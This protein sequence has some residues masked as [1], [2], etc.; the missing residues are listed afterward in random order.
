MIRLYYARPRPAIPGRAVFFRETA[1]ILTDM[2]RKVSV[3]KLPLRRLLWLLLPI[4]LA[5][6]MC[7]GG[8][9]AAGHGDAPDIY[10]LLLRSAGLPA[11]DPEPVAEEEPEPPEEALLVVAKAKPQERIRAVV[12][13]THTSE[14]YKGQS[15]QKGVPGGVLEA[16][17]ELARALTEQGLEV[18]FDETVHDYDYDAAYSHS[19][20][21][22]EEIVAAYPDTRLFIDVHRDSAIAGIS[23]TLQA[24]GQDYAKMLLI[25]GS[26]EN[27]PHENWQA[28]YAF[29]KKVAA[30]TERLLPGVMREPRVYS[31]RYNQH[32]GDRALLVE[33]GSTDNSVEEARRSAAVL[34]RA[35]AAS[36]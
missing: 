1:H 21:A 4:L 6:L 23:T 29:A 16:A 2:K 35:I 28:N 20:A 10:E 8:P 11:L 33:I 25:V 17:R 22:L 18:I 3:I 7:R 30:E 24:E 32:I 13:C 26:D 15:R 14:E 5:A 19:L 34:A 12:Y 31:G 36:L 27:L 9:A